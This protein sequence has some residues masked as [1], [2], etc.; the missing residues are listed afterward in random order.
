MQTAK[1]IA[2]YLIP[3]AI[4]LSDCNRE[5]TAVSGS[6]WQSSVEK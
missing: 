6:P 4:N 5:L 3:A 1:E 2:L